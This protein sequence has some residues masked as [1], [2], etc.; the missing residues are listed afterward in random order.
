MS[1]GLAPEPT[2]PRATTGGF[3]NELVV[4]RGM[5]RLLPWGIAA[6]ALVVTAL[7]L[8]LLNRLQPALLALAFV[9]VFVAALVVVSAR[10]EG[11]RKAVDRAVMAAVYSCFALAVIPLLSVLGTT[12]VRG[13]ERFDA[14]FF[15]RSMNRIIGNNPG[16]GAY[17]AIVGTIQQV[18]IATI[19]SVPIGLL[20]AIY[21]VEYGRGKL[22]RAVTF[23]VDVMTGVPSIVA[24]LF[25]LTLFL[26]TL[27]FTYAGVFGALALTIL[28]LPV[29]VRAAEEMLRLVPDELREAALALGVPRWR[30]ILK[31]V[32]PTALPGIITGVML[33]IA[34]VIGETAPLLLTVFVT[35]VIN[36]NP[37][38]NPQMSLPLFVY[39]EIGKGR[40]AALDRAWSAALT[41]ILIV[42]LLNLV[43]RLIA[44]WK[45]PARS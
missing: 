40:E 28:M 23:F 5:P 3:R 20:V 36:Y 14:E 38:A 24:G 41:L 17:H 39:T 22:A 21:L 11:R 19:L 45:A 29:V 34:R 9:P 37:F 2:A 31:I 33:A 16:G 27:P 1:T 43:A 42:L 35:N 18:G 10:L 4:R 8:L 32:L 13:L 25:I 26:L 15:T 7:V 12:I 30:T 44:W 6:A